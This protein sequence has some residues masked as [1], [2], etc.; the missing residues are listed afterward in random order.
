MTRGPR[1]LEDHV[2]TV[3]AYLNDYKKTELRKQRDE[4]SKKFNCYLLSTC[5][6]KIVK[7]VKSWQVLGFVR[8]LTIMIPL[9]EYKRRGREWADFPSNIGPG[10]KTLR[11]LLNR[12]ADKNLRKTLVL[13]YIPPS[14]DHPP[15]ING[16]FVNTE[17]VLFSKETMLDFHFLVVGAFRGF[18]CAF[19]DMARGYEKLVR[20]DYK[21]LEM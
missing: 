7:R 8:F 1:P 14:T 2:A 18:A 6:S 17:S 21:A 13:N 11:T 5:W 4:I 12:L 16:L 3:N 10:D 15:S 19:L 9:D 20:I